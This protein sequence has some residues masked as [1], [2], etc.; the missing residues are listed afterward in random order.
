MAVYVSGGCKLYTYYLQPE[1]ITLRDSPSYMQ[2]SLARLRYRAFQK[3]KHSH[4][5]NHQCSTSFSHQPLLYSSIP[6]PVPSLRGSHA[7]VASV[8]GSLSTKPT[9][10]T[11]RVASSASFKSSI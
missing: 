2:P 11:A 5:D 4:F 8:A 7:A 3:S 1:H 10:L 9:L 6:S